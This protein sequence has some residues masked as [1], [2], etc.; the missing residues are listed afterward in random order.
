[1]F[2]Q[3]YLFTLKLFAQY[4]GH[5]EVKVVGEQGL[6]RLRQSLTFIKDEYSRFMRKCTDKMAALKS[7]ESTKISVERMREK[8]KEAYLRCEY[9]LELFGVCYKQKD[10]DSMVKELKVKINEGR[11][12][13]MFDSHELRRFL[14]INRSKELHD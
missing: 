11:T 2:S 9:I 4:L 7:D 3:A 6:F 5:L 8:N 14:Q 12:I 10:F 1:M 13:H